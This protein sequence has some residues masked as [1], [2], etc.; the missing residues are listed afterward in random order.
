MWMVRNKC[1]ATFAQQCSLSSHIAWKRDWSWKKNIKIWVGFFFRRVTFLSFLFWNLYF[2]LLLLACYYTY[3][4]LLSSCY[5]SPFWY[6]LYNIDVKHMYQKRW[7]NINKNYKIN[8]I[9]TYD[10]HRISWSQPIFQDVFQIRFLDELSIRQQKASKCAWNVPKT[11]NAP[12]PSGKKLVF[13]L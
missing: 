12:I 4:S 3:S 11:S 7:V 2:F 1:S 5:S 9:A 10:L 13:K 6:S 8:T